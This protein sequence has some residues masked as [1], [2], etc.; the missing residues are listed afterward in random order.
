MD[1]VTEGIGELNAPYELLPCPFCGKSDFLVER[2]DYSSSM[3]ICQG[4]VTE[5]SACLAQGPVGVQDDNGEDQPGKAA[6]IREWNRRATRATQNEQPPVP[7]QEWAGGECPV[8]AGTLVEYR[9]SRDA[10][11]TFHAAE[12]AERL[13]WAHHRGRAR[14]SNIVEYRIAN[15]VAQ[16]EL[17][18][19]LHITHRPLIRNVISLLGLRRPVAADVQRVIDDLET[20]LK[21]APTPADPT[22]AHWLEVA[23]AAEKS[24]LVEIVRTMASQ[25]EH[26]FENDDQCHCGSCVLI[27]KARAALAAQRG[28]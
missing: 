8:P 24:E 6:A 26:G 10:R 18:E 12:S 28:E 4:M 14:S 9:M 3:V 13:D 1:K 20:M 7:W 21:G 5:Y 25:G 16:A 17:V 19:A 23:H 27:R 2:L 15:P 22:A 11:S